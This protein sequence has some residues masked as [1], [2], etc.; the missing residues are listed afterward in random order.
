MF[1]HKCGSKPPEG[2][3]FCSKCGT[4]IAS[5][6]AEIESPATAS[7]DNLSTIGEETVIMEG[8]CNRVKSKSHVQNGKGTL[9]NKR[10]VYQEKFRALRDALSIVPDIVDLLGGETG[11]A[12]NALGSLTAEDMDFSIRLSDIVGIEY[13][14]QGIS[15]T[16]ILNT[17]SG[18][19]FNFYFTKR[20]QWKSAIQDAINATIGG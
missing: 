9:T 3:M 10:F 11:G 18:E 4:K 17:K 5:S 12:N 14:R 1:C 16:L 6:N 20:E 7:Q 8:L 2:A 13:G 15:K 19:S